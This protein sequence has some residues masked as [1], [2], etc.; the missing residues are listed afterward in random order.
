M[1]NFTLFAVSAILAGSGMVAFLSR[2][3][4]R[5]ASVQPP[6]EETG[7]P[8]A[9]PPIRTHDEAFLG[10]MHDLIEEHLSEEEFN[11]SSLAAM[12]GLSRS[13]LFSKVKA[14]TGLSPQE[15]LSDS[16]LSRARTLLLTHEFNISEVAYKVGFSTLNGLSRAFKKKYGMPPSAL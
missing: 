4:S 15:I 14:L 7:H 9:E 12:M 10:K 16:R 8:L 13:S 6:V 1:K 11:V 2:R 3:R 5:P